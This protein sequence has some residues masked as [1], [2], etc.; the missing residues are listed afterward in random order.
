MSIIRDG[1][2]NKAAGVDST[3]RLMVRAV[4]QSETESATDSGDSYNINS[5]LITLT[6][7]GE[8]GVIY[9]KNNENSNIHIDSVVVIL[10]PSA[11]GVTTDTTLIKMY[12]NPTTGTLISGASDVD[13]NENRNFGSPHNLTAD[14]YKGAEGNTITNGVVI[15]ESLIN[16]GT[17]VAFKIDMVL[18]KGD[19]IAVSYE[20]NDSNTSMKCMAAI[21][22]H[23]EPSV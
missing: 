8:S 14:A 21:L 10:G 7:A 20:P 6:T 2:T 13:D 16:P 11:N 9:L 22:L 12:R 1:S 4:Q 15:V 5:G 3:S 18:T 19:S 23:I 17:R